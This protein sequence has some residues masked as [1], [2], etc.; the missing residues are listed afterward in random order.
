MRKLFFLIVG[1]V[2][3]ANVLANVNK[4]EITQ[5]EE[6]VFTISAEGKNVKL[7]NIDRIGPYKI[8][9]SSKSEN[10]TIINGEFHSTISKSY[11][12]YPMHD[13][14]IPS[15]KV[16]VDGKI[17]Y[18]KPIFIKVKKLKKTNYKDY[19]LTVSLDKNTTYL[20]EGR[21]LTIKFFQSID[22]NPQSIQIQRPL[23]K[24]FLIKQILSKS[25]IEDNRKII[26]Y[27]FF[28][29]P[30]KSGIFKIGP[31]IANV[32]I[33]RKENPF[34]NP[35]FS[36]SFI[37]YKKVVSN[38]MNL[39][40]N[41][42]PNGSIW[43][44]FNINLTADKKIAFANTPIKILLEI[45]GCGDFY[46]MRDFKLLIPNATIY[47]KKPVLKTFIKGNKLCGI[48]KKEFDVISPS[49][50][51]ISGIGLLEFN[52]TLHYIKSNPLFIKIKNSLLSTK[53]ENFTNEE[54]ENN[55]K[56]V[57]YKTNYVLVVVAF[58]LGMI[59]G[60]FIKS[61]LL[62]KSKKE[63]DIIEKVKSANEK[64]LFKLLLPY[65]YDKRIEKFLKQLE[66]NLYK[67]GKNKINKKEIIRLLNELNQF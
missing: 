11:V 32:G 31:L 56:K 46:D 50:I 29:L 43:G 67:N 16:M 41:P 60:I 52:G 28:I 37:T 21:I 2:L 63:K 17:Y 61:I 64:E 23:L 45:K 40:V 48:Y 18:T 19:N 22:S 42:I 51:N 7:P 12:F 36:T 49:D 4:K 58:F 33:L 54:N 57:V 14:T 35:F 26:E 20:G 13:V 3:Y 27:K 5:G 1:I 6:V 53:I 25:Y 59:I 47:E 66:E 65:S 34:D 39:K 55:E 15:F 9:A 62:L 30:Q 24:D 44:N 38:E 10:I 8:K